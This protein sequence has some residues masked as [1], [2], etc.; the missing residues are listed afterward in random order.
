VKNGA[1]ADAYCRDGFCV[2]PSRSFLEVQKLSV[3]YGERQVLKEVH[4]SF[5]AC[6]IVALIGP[7][8]CGKTTFLSTLNRLTDLYPSC[9]V[10]GSI[11]MGDLS[12]LEPKL[13]V[14][15][16]RKRVGM[17]FQKPNPF[18]LSIYRNIA[19]PL[20][21]HQRLRKD[22]IAYRV[23]LALRDVGLWE[24]VKDRL[25]HSALQLSGGQQQRLCIA[26]CIALEPEVI[27]L[28]EPCSALD[29]L[30]TETI[31]GLLQKLRSRY[32]LMVVTHNLAQA[33]RL[34]DEVAV[35]WVV[36]GCGR[37]IE[38]GPTERIFLDPI[39]PRTRAYV[40]GL[41]G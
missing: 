26:R 29:P 18:P 35:F 7:S 21:E 1:G 25:H 9:R 13:D 37:L 11:R 5:S 34:A 6:S 16:L 41:I 24:E 28:D 20:S 14:R 22:E 38:N 33:R 31:E 23:E 4:A 19:W 27:L 30:A 10:T 8:G 40:S 39:E 2:L 12:I 32:H 17:V 36:E 3:W 15:R